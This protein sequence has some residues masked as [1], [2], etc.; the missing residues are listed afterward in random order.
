MKFLRQELIK[1][2]PHKKYGALS[3]LNI[4]LIL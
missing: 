2:A 1:K 3:V 4:K